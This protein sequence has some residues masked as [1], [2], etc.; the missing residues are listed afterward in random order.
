MKAYAS[1]AEWK[2]DQSLKNRRLIGALE[3][4]IEGVSPEWQRFVKWGQGCWVNEGVPKVYLHTEPDHVQLGFYYGVKMKDPDKLLV[5]SA[6][7]VRHV[8]VRTP[9]DIHAEQL[10]ALIEQLRG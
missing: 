6:K 1:Y 9:K 8:K 7:H 10:E 2:K 3:R 5:G 4:I